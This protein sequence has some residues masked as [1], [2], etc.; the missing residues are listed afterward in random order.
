MGKFDGM[1]LASDFDGTLYYNG[2]I[3]EEN[4]K[5]IKYFQDNGG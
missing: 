2:N 5:D 4:L 3:S 1:L